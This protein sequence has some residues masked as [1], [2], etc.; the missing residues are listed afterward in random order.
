MDPR[1][2]GHGRRW[3]RAALIVPALVLGLAVAAPGSALAADVGFADFS[4]GTGVTAPTGQKPQSKLWHTAGGQWWGVLWSTANNAWT[5][6]KFDKATQKWTTTT[7]KV[8]TRRT[9]GPDAFY[10]SSNST[11]YVVTALKEG[12]TQTDDRVLV[13]RFSFNG[14]SWSQIGT[15]V[16]VLN[17]KP[18]TIVMDRDSTGKLWLT[19]TKTNTANALKSVY[20]AHTTTSEATWGAPYVLPLASANNLS[21]DDIST[22]VTYGAGTKYTGVLWSN[23]NDNTL[24]FARHVD[25]A[26][27]TAAS[28][29]KIVLASGAFLPDDHLNIKG[30]LDDG[31]GRVFAVVKT[32]LNDK[33]PSVATDPLIVLYTINGTSVT[34]QTVWRVGDDVTRA[35]MLL[36]TTNQQVHLFG[37]GPCCSGGTVYYKSSSYNTPSF[38][39][40]LGTPFIQLAAHTVINNPTSTKQ[41]VNATTGLLVEAGNDATRTYV[42]NF[43]SL[44][45]ADTTPPE[46]TIDSG[47]TGT[48]ASVDASFAFSSSETGSTFE[49][50]ID[51]GAWGACT[52]P[53]AY[54]GL[55]AGTHTF[56][57]RA[58]DA[59]GNTD[60]TPASRTWTISTAS[61]S[62][63]TFNAVADSYV[64]ASHATTNYGS[65]LALTA[66]TSPVERALLRFDVSGLSGNVT[67]AK[68]RLYATGGSTN[69]PAVYATTG[70]WT[71]TGVNS[72]NAPAPVGTASD[73]KGAV[74][75]GTTVEF[76]VKPLVSGNGTVNFILVGTSSDGT[77]V[78]SREAII[79]ARRPQLI[80]TTDGGTP[81]SDTT[82]PDTSITSGPPSSTAD[83]TASFAFTSSET[84]STFECRLDTGAWGTCTTP[85]AYSGLAVGQH[86][87][88]VRA[89]D[90]ANNTDTTPASQTWTIT[91]RRR[92]TPRRPTPPSPAG[93][94][95][96][97]PTRPR[98]SRSPPAKP[99]RRSNA[100]STPAPGAP[101]PHRRPTAAS[102]PAS[103]PSTCAPPTPPTTPT[104]PRRRRRGR[105]PPR[106]RPTPR[107][108]T[109]R[110]LA[111]RRRSTTDTTAS[112]AFTSTETGSTFECRLDTGA[113][114]ACTSPKAYT[115]LAV[116]QHTFDVRA[117]DTANNT[118]TTPASQT[119][120]ITSTGPGALFSDGFEG[121]GFGAAWTTQTAGGGTATVQTAVKKTGTSAA[122]LTTT[123]AAG[124]IAWARHPFATPLTDFTVKGAFNVISEGAS[125]GN[126]PLLRL[127]DPSGTASANRLVVLYRQNATN[128]KL[129]LTLGAT[130]VDT[131][132]LMPIGGWVDVELSVKVAGAS[133]VVTLKLN[134]TQVYTTS[135]ASLGTAGVKTLQLGNETSA[136]AGD[137]AV[138]DLVV[139][140]S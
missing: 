115:G 121:T 132:S 118:D 44:G 51:N 37:A 43:L 122:R 79:A 17:G 116:G 91:T 20:V 97:P 130:R 94:R 120:T 68:L 84:G 129:Y 40:G 95:R 66:D 81:P 70:S 89:T 78:S 82:P 87:F 111:G 15:A 64:D 69:G 38:P 133:S 137:V 77:D 45:S 88:D 53:K 12:S 26:G 7:V 110:S 125:G 123:S 47:P 18:E 108:P 100:A 124:S 113:W 9:G 117:T 140:G 13:T 39:T 24:N 34:Q 72:N 22:I 8:D 36:D 61:T 23:E 109:P 101:A 14:T 10:V 65:A 58:T 57:V 30:L 138:D 29:Q 46:T 31:S 33:S 62:T 126:V 99:G 32:S 136:Q 74:T 131:T 80:V 90:T 128:G 86:T 28:W 75:A 4:Y 71:E 112:F 104:P 103:T 67:S 135:T 102:P 2:P 134:G 1:G 98:R 60:A 119:W 42:H 54:T 93:R 5:I 59:A 16:N 50:R 19:Y 52:S 48:T 3:L 83:T 27:D 92:P 114:G 139:T 49:C 73:D 6:Q 63:G 55:A 106:R 25:G 76:D 41:S 127:F 107:R 96:R 56:D 35:I 105:S 85:K 11:L 21:T